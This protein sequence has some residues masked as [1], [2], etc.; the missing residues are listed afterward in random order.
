MVRRHLAFLLGTLAFAVAQYFWLRSALAAPAGAPGTFLEAEWAWLVA[1]VH[2]PLR[3]ATVWTFVL[4]ANVAYL[5]NLVYHLGGRPRWQVWGYV[6]WYPALFLFFVAV[7]TGPAGV[8]WHFGG[9]HR[10]LLFGLF[11]LLTTTCYHVPVLFGFLVCVLAAYFVLPFYAEATLGLLCVL[12][13]VG[14]ALAG[15][16]RRRHNYVVLVSFVVGFVLLVVVFFP[17]VNLAFWRSPQ[18]LDRLVRGTDPGAAA[19]RRAIWVSLKTATVSTLVVLVLGVP[20]AY[21]LVRGRF[22]GRGVLDALVD[23]PIVLPPPAAGIALAM[24]VGPDPGFATWLKEHLGLE[25]AGDWKGICLAQIFVSSPFLIRSAMAAFRAI[26]P[27]LEHVSRTLGARP[28][29][30]FGRV[31]LPLAARG[32]FMGCILTWGRAIGEFGSVVILASDPQTM[33]VRIYDL[34]VG[35]GD[36]GPSLTV[37]ILMVLMCTAIFAGLHLVASRTVW[38]NV[39]TLWSRLGGSS[40]EPEQAAG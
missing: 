18:D 6:V 8:R 17:L 13:L 20:L 3:G 31:S 26:D 30:T 7:A 38:R 10:L 4:I 27:R 40:G 32:I 9:M 37:A 14:L 35:S 24:L 11:L 21:V 15:Y 19:T 34:F 28:L 16:A 36:K 12:Y 2:M 22:P 33:P 39:R 23:L 1:F 29:A 25:L 5:Y